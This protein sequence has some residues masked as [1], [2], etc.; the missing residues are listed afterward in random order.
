[1]HYYVLFSF[2][3]CDARFSTVA[4]YLPFTYSILRKKVTVLF[5]ISLAW[6]AWAGCNRAE[7]LSQPGTHFFAP[8]CRV[9]SS[10][11]SELRI[12]DVFI[13]FC[14]PQKSLN[15]AAAAHPA[16][17]GDFSRWFYPTRERAARQL[18]EE[19]RRGQPAAASLRLEGEE[20]EGEGKEEH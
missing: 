18:Q 15:A 11:T 6:L 1:M 10:G 19:E 12:P 7:L 16:V 14:K 2:L 3:K 13:T 17:D 9:F 5:S 4:R 20:G 8:P